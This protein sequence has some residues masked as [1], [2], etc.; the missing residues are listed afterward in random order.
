MALVSLLSVC[1]LVLPYICLF[2][3]ELQLKNYTLPCFVKLG[4]DL[5]ETTA[6]VSIFF[7]DSLSAPR[8]QETKA[9]FQKQLRG[10]ADNV[11]WFFKKIQNFLEMKSSL[12][13]VPLIRLLHLTLVLRLAVMLLAILPAV[14]RE[15]VAIFILS[16]LLTVSMEI[17]KTLLLT[18]FDKFTK[19]FPR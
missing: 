5:G 15:L 10:W 1:V 14:A 6:N 12:L 17:K 7:N 19:N 3:I 8:C 4:S 9:F 11:W 2:V 18:L 16:M 13:S